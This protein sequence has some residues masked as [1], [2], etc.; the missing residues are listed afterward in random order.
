VRAAPEPAGGP[1]GMFFNAN[2][3]ADPDGNPATPFFFGDYVLFNGGATT[4]AFPNPAVGLLLG[5][6]PPPVGAANAFADNFVI[7]GNAPL[8]GPF[9]DIQF[10]FEADCSFYGADADADCYCETANPLVLIFDQCP[11]SDDNFDAPP[12]DGTN[13]TD[14]DGVHE[15]AD[16]CDF[17][18][19][20]SQ[21][22]ADSD[23]VGD[24]CDNCVNDANPAQTDTDG[25]T[26]GDA[27]DQ[28]PGLDDLLDTDGDT[29]PDCL[30]NCPADSNT[31][32]EDL[33]N[34]GIGDVCDDEDTLNGFG[35]RRLIFSKSNNAGKDKWQAQGEVSTGEQP[36]FLADADAQGLSLSVR[37]SMGTLIDSENFTGADCVRVGVNQ[38]SIRCKNVLGSQL[39]LQKRGTPE[40]FRVVIS[41]RNQAFF[42]PNV[43][44]VPMQL[45]MS[46]PDSIDRNAEIGGAAGGTCVLRG[47]RVVCQN[48]P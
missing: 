11:G 22:D 13:D 44:N 4:P 37:D 45:R 39:R 24:A 35:L 38:N 40:F 23:L 19:N 18:V 33:D 7:N 3:A 36:N 16:N 26:V 27:C 41:V 6:G 47:N 15:C 9:D 17:V 31:G 1:G 32:Q 46:G 28:C 30:D 48:T 5:V 42:M 14:G 2:P 43:A 21:A 8:A 10:D 12:A 20:P 34:D 29:V 25:D